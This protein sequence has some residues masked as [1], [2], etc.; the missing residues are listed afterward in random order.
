MVV[1]TT[2]NGKQ[3]IDLL[4]RETVSIILMDC[5]M[6]EMDG[7]QATKH[8]RATEGVGEHTPIIAVTA[9]GMSKDRQ[10]CLDSGMDDYIKKPIKP[11][12]MKQILQ[13][14]LPHKTT[15]VQKIKEQS[16]Q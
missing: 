16:A 1:L 7:F 8:I 5:Q 15:S 10:M 12:E 2:D 9:N 11:Q 6:P 4:A 14:W 3:A 13:R